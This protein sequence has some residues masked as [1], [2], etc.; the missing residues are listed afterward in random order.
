MVPG[1]SAKTVTATSSMMNLTWNLFVRN[2]G[3]SCSSA[4]NAE[5]AISAMDAWGS[6]PAKRLFGKRNRKSGSWGHGCLIAFMRSSREFILQ[7][8][9]LRSFF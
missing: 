3:T 2:A 6:F 9:I 8:P 4:G 5:I 1:F 7:L